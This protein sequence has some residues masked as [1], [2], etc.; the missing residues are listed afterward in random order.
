MVTPLDTRRKG[1]T[2]SFSNEV[3]R[4]STSSRSKLSCING[5]TSRHKGEG[6]HPFIYNV[7][8]RR[9]TTSRL[10]LSCNSGS[11]SRHR[12]V[13]WQPP[14]PLVAKKQ[15]EPGLPLVHVP[16]PSPMLLSLGLDKILVV[17]ELARLVASSARLD[18]AR[19]NLSRAEL[20]SQLGSLTSQLVSSN[21]LAFIC[22]QSLY[23]YWMN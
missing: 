5:Y 22:K 16:P 23:L 14:T 21:E 15:E 11:T 6:Y 19:F 7:A 10:G 17:R 4:R 13:W 1:T 9:G 12:R 8:S 20:T 2:P 18:S 3:L